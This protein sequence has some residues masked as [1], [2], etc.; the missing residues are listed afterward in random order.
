MA[1]TTIHPITATIGASISYITAAHKTEEL[2]YVD[3][4]ECGIM[5]IAVIY[6]FD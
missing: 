5:I 1:I 6:L 2:L 4:F 3:S